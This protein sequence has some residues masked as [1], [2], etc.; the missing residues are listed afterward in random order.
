M[1]IL[2]EWREFKSIHEGWNVAAGCIEPLHTV[3]V[4]AEEVVVTLDLPYVTSKEVKLRCPANDV[5]EIFAETSK[6]ITFKALGAKHRHGEFTY[7][8]VRIRIPVHIDERKISSRLKHG[9]LE[10]HISRVK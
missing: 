7:Y 4:G 9:V 8:H 1:S 5:L 2:G 10:F 6:K 3:S